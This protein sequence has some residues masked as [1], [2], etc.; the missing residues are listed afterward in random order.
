MPRDAQYKKKFSER[1]TKHILR[2]EIW[3][4]ILE[5]WDSIR[6]KI[7]CVGVVLYRSRWQAARA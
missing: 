4:V 6:K 5:T 2:Q 7:W 1:Y 3:R